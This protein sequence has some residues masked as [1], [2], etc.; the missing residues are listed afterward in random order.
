MK[1]YTEWRKAWNLGKIEAVV[2]LAVVGLAVCYITECII[3]I[4]LKTI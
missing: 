2:F 3:I 1:K 4:I